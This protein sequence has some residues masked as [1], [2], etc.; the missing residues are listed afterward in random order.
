MVI[1][2]K[3]KLPIVSSDG[4]DYYLERQEEPIPQ[5]EQ[6]LFDGISDD[7]AKKK[8]MERIKPFRVY[9]KDSN[10]SVLGGATGVTFFMAVFMLT[11]CRL[12][13][14]FAIRDL[15]KK[16]WKRLNKLIK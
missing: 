4:G 16:S 10:Q 8:G 3:K 1:W 9:I 7:A 11:C 13:N 2:L 12:K 14:Q 15:A 6:V 5:D